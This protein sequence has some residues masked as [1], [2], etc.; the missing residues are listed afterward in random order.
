MKEIRTW[1]LEEQIRHIIALGK[2]GELS[3]QIANEKRSATATGNGV[4]IVK[5]NG[6]LVAL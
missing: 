2:I 3:Q 4:K 1:S 6:R 5:R